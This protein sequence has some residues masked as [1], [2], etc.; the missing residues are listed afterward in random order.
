[1]KAN[2]I[3]FFLIILLL[4]T[5]SLTINAQYGYSPFIDS[6][7][8]QVTDSSLALLNRQLSGDTSVMIGGN[9]CTIVSRNAYYSG[10]ALAAQFILE[11]FQSYGLD[12]YLHNY[13]PNGQNVVATITGTEYPDQQ[14]II[15]GHY[16]AMPNG[17]VA[18]GADDNASGVCAL[19]EAARIMSNYSF[20]YTL[21]FI[22]FDEEEQGLI[23][24][25]Y[26]ANWAYANGHQILGVLNQDMI[27]WDGNG[28]FEYS[29]SANT[30]SLPFLN[31]HIDNMRN[32]QPILSPSVISSIASDHYRFWAKGYPALM[33]IEHHYFDFH[34]AY[35]SINDHFDSINI[36]YFVTMTRGVIASFMALAWDHRM[37]LSHEPLETK[38][39]TGERTAKLI[40]NGPNPPDTGVNSPRMYYRI[41][42]QAFEYV[43]PQSV[44]GDTFNFVMPGFPLG[45]RVS[46]YFAAQD[47]SGEFVVTLPEYGR[48]LNP[49]GGIQPP[50]LFTYSVLE[51]T[52]IAYCATNLPDTIPAGDTL[53]K[54]L[55]IPA[56]GQILDL[57]VELNI[58][59]T[60]CRDLNLFLISPSGRE[61]LLS[62]QNGF[63]LDNYTNTIF[64]DEAALM[65]AQS[66]P[67]FTGSFRPE[68]PLAILR[69][70]TMQ[71]TWALKIIN[72]GTTG[73]SL[74][75]FCLHFQI[76][77]DCK[78]VDVSRPCSGDGQTWETALTSISEAVS[79]NPEP[80]SVILIKPGIYEENLVIGT[81]GA[82]IVPFTPGIEVNDTNRI[83]FPSG[84]DLSAIDLINLPGKYFAYIFRSRYWNNGF[85]QI[86]EVNDSLDFVRVNNIVFRDEAGQVGDSSLISAAIALPVIYRKYSVN[87]DVERVVLDSILLNDPAI[88]IGTP[89]GDGNLDANPANYNIIEGIDISGNASGIGVH[90]Q[91]S[92]FNVVCNSKIYDS[93]SI[94]VYINGNA[95]HPALFNIIAGNEIYDSP[96][97]G[98]SIGN[99]YL[100][101]YN[102]HAHFSHIIGNDIHP[103]ANRSSAQMA[104]ALHIS[105]YNR[106]TVVER[107]FIHDFQLQQTNMGAV[108]VHSHA[109]GT[110]INGNIIKNIG[111]IAEG[112]NACVRIHGYL[113]NIRISNNI[114]YNSVAGDDN[115]Y[116]F[117]I[118]G[119][120][121]QGSRLIHNTVF[122]LEKCFLLE[123]YTDSSEFG[124][125]NNLIQVNETYFNSM[126]TTGTFDLS[127][128]LYFSDPVPD[129][130]MPYFF[131]PG[132]Q[133]GSVDFADAGSGDFRLTIRS[134]KA[135]C[136]GIAL[137]PALGIDINGVERVTS[138]P[139]IGA[140]EL[141]NKLLWLGTDNIDW[142]NPMNWL[143]NSIPGENSNVVIQDAEN[144]PIIYNGNAIAG[145]IL[146]KP[147]AHLKINQDKTLETAN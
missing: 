90:I 102:S 57:D 60:N 2:R 54:T 129:P 143:G 53:L 67:P 103:A 32:Y 77:V 121:H 134:E 17:E 22:A 25:Q 59:H 127:N 45:S 8:L 125:Y 107:N 98:I 71:G 79:S 139:D 144:D 116:G 62:S 68:H 141:E 84:T 146:I 13:D 97:F 19:L 85:Y 12:A 63:T 142:H 117:W 52:S 82:Q 113:N 30:A 56:G 42:D 94:G 70:T 74:Y 55:E 87:P 3:S 34:P 140:C 49:P 51:D 135:I 43:T 100:P 20:P 138:L 132:R 131:E 29:V 11:K 89:I 21:K 16:D 136:N 78:Y 91:S 105:E 76:A 93:D 39:W 15:C 35:H 111:K 69:D 106:N 109:H 130:G 122:N 4:Y 66:L 124:I 44:I 9:T 23:G 86:S 24:S 73:G 72:T 6:L 1:M 50:M 114:L 80:G 46:Y 14:Y 104:N 7:T 58:S 28:D 92:S 120:D 83:Q 81:N 75:S 26:Y 10:N 133:V 128:N 37:E 96:F 61:I 33:T 64:D 137:S 27:S 18:P 88:Y 41:D 115:F 118:D 145:G 38:L 112:T 110:R 123:N 5:N 126:G 119:S 65:I 147:G 36:P 40:I 108:E 101:E 31:V 47:S 95:D 99:D 48:G